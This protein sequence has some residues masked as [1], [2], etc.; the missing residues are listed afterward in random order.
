MLQDHWCKLRKF[1]NK[2]VSFSEGKRIC[3]DEAVSIT[4]G[5]T[6]VN[7][8]FSHHGD[9]AR[10]YEGRNVW[11]VCRLPDAAAFVDASVRGP[12]SVRRTLNVSQ[13]HVVLLSLPTSVVSLEEPQVNIKQGNPIL[14][15]QN[16]MFFSEVCLIFKDV[17]PNV[18]KTDL[19]PRHI[20]TTSISE[21]PGP[22]PGSHTIFFCIFVSFYL[23]YNCFQNFLICE[24]VYTCRTN[25]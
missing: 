22:S 4:S 12:R 19:P 11:R 23:S 8:S 2:S 1:L 17:C 5:L 9:D 25:K 21:S 3:S 7:N 20:S 13:N 16:P 24:Y 18:L 14:H 10:E 15:S 6:E